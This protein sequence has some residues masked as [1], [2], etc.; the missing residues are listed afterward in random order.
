VVVVV[1]LLLLLQEQPTDNPACQAD[2]TY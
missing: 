2:G 1:L